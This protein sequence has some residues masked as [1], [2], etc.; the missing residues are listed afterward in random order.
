M[1]KIREIDYGLAFF[2]T[3]KKK[4]WIELNKHLKKYPKLRRKIFKHEMGHVRNHRQNKNILHDFWWDTKSLFDVKGG[5]EIAKFSCKHPRAF[6]ANSPV[7]YENKRWSVNWFMAFVNLII[8]SGVI[9][10]FSLI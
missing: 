9:M 2:V 3:S 10:G 5:W 1:I 4:S 8:I 6:M 7:F